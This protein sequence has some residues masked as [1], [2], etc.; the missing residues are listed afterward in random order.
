M[1]YL[2]WLDDLDFGLLRN[3]LFKLETAKFKMFPLVVNVHIILRLALQMESTGSLKTKI[4]ALFMIMLAATLAF[5]FILP[6]AEAV[7][8]AITSVSPVTKIGK[9]G[10]DVRIMGT[11]NSTGGRYR[12]FFR[13]Q[14]V[15]DQNA[16]GNNVNATFKVPQT[17]KGN[18]TIIL[19]DVD[20]NIN[21]T[22]SFIVNTVYHVKVDKSSLVAPTQWQQG[23]SVTLWVNIT[24]GEA[25]KA[26][27]ANVTVKVPSPANETYW[28]ILRFNTSDVGY[29]ARMVTYP[30][31]SFSGTLGSHTN[32]TGAYTVAYNTTG[33]TDS[34]FIGLTNAS[35]YHRYQFV[36]IKAIG[37]KSNESVNIK[38]TDGNLTHSENK[39]ALPDGVVNANW[40]IPSNAAVDTY[41]VNITSIAPSNQTKT[42]KIP[43]DVQTFKVPGFSVNV[44]TRNLASEPVPY[45]TLNVRDERNMSIARI[46]GGADGIVL[47]MLETGNYT[48]EAIFKTVPVGKRSLNVT[49]VALFDLTCNLTNLRISVV[50]FKDG[51]AISV[52]EVRMYITPENR[53]LFTGINGTTVVHSLLPNRNYTVNAYRYNVQFNVTTI[54]G[55]LVGGNL[56]TWFNTTITCPL[57]TLRVDAKDASG[58][59]ISGAKVEV[60][61]LMGGLSYEGNTDAEGTVSFNCTLGKYTVIAYDADGI[62]LNKTSVNLLNITSQLNN[63]SVSC[64]LYGLTVSVKVVDY[65]GQPVSNVNVTLQREGSASRSALTPSNGTTRF[66]PVTG[67]TLQAIIYLSGQ[68]EPHL[69]TTFTAVKS[70]T[71]EVKL[72]RYML[73]AGSFIEVDHLA[74]ALVV[75][76]TVLLIL[77]VEIYRRRRLKSQKPESE[78]E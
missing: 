36:D 27:A 76:A 57:L 33:V 66:A 59:Q 65:F 5:S 14:I 74:T 46:T 47:L 17:P 7:G 39:T 77:S 44:T 64:Q 43:P 63:V 21:A 34:F 49:D 55:L 20:K 70:T 9:V 72:D 12:I 60:R 58:A 53:E 52:P 23:Q 61:E 67:G 54:P 42:K 69:A 2:S 8:V 11:I 25:N 41:K 37:Y 56:V 4:M 10:D 16:S 50:T 62:E 24:G 3:G 19:Q 31:A 22:S 35:D 26:N 1:I 71:I 38:I 48:C 30:N 73:L 78:S 15:V 29:G 18:H 68:T 51:V 40:T 45:V 13:N 28:S 32:Y 75:L 6:R